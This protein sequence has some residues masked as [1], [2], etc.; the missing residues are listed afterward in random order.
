VT[1]LV[2]VVARAQ[3]PGRPASAAEGIAPV[4][5]VTGT[6]SAVGDGDPHAGIPG[7]PPR[8]RAFSI[9]E[10]SDAVPAGTI[11]VTVLDAAGTPVPDAEVDLGVMAQG[12]LRDRKLARTGPDGNVRFEGLPTG[13]GQAYRVNVPYQG[14]R[15]SSSPFQLPPDRGYEVHLVRLPTTRDERF[16]LQVLGETLIELREGRAH[17]IQRSRLMN[18]GQA[19]YVFP[20]TGLRIPL[21][22]GFMAPQTEPL[23][24]DQRLVGTDE[25]WKLLG[26][27][28][29]GAVTLAWAYDVAL[30]G[31]ALSLRIPQPFRTYVYRVITDAPP[32]AR[33]TVVSEVAE[34]TGATRHAEFARP[35]R[36]ESGGRSLLVTQLERTPEDPPLDAVVIVLEGLPTPGPWRWLAV[37]GA[38]ALAGGG[39]FLALTRNPPAPDLDA[40]RSRREALVSEIRALD[41]S[42]ADGVVGPKH[43]AR[44]RARLLEELAAVLRVEDQNAPRKPPSATARSATSRRRPPGSS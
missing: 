38:V 23:M 21:P 22:P 12:G 19:T 16:L 8:T 42:L 2:P 3:D 7:A 35:Q 34:V 36:A 40:L 32:G 43:H 33:L 6:R 37:L 27:I 9:A 17:V 10:P 31:D 25:G 20:E 30:E 13:T 5:G 41:R 29:P 24:T 11:A 44:R 4:D 28:P 26:S 1:L 18:L 15:Y 14:A 39:L